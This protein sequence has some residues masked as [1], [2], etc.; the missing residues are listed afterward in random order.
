MAVREAEPSTILASLDE[1]AERRAQ[2]L[3]FESLV[4]DGCGGIKY[5][6]EHFD[7]LAAGGVNVL[8][9]TV[10]WPLSGLREA[11]RDIAFCRRWIHEHRDR[12][13]L[14]E[15]VADI[16]DA[17][18]TGR[19]AIVLGPQ[20]SE[21]IERD[22]GAIATFF[23][24]GIR[25][26]QL[27]Y[28]TANWIGSGCGEPN[29]GGLTRFGRDVIRAMHEVGMV[30]DLSHC[31]HPTSMDAVEF[32]EGPVIFSHAS[33][34]AV[35]PHVRTKKDDVIR[36]LAEKGGVIGLTALSVQNELEPNVRP[37]MDAFAR[38]VDHLLNLVGP[39]HIGIGLDFH[40]HRTPETHAAAHK[41]NPE[42]GSAYRF[43][44]RR[45]IELSDFPEAPNI[46]RTLVGMGLGDDEITKI[47]GLNFL[48]VFEEVWPEG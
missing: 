41:V 31:S 46:T 4:I 23:D 16:K 10:T 8:S 5:E 2:R 13:L 30:V 27:T 47:L 45:I 29:P 7:R 3:H 12:G 40:E 20:H 43:E 15:T 25:I 26:M 1:A 22:T 35:T 6:P 32:A 36:A 34:H 48:R 9:H 19:E 14:V 44:Q 39:D 42:L 33:V 38:H 17:F 21:F 37:S 18:A 24:L 11:Q 28:Q